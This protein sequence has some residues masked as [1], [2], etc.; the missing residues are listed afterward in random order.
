MSANLFGTRIRAL[1]E[2]RDLT[3][4]QLADRLGFKD[5]Q[6][7]SA[8]ETGDRRLSADELLRAA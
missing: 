8:I 3:Q 5:R 2:A 7:L 1:R 4:D 6:T